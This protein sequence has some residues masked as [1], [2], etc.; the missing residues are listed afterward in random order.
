MLNNMDKIVAAGRL[1]DVVKIFGD[2][3]DSLALDLNA[4]V[5]ADETEV[6]D[7]KNELK[8]PNWCKKVSARLIA[9]YSKDV[10]RKKTAPI[11]AL[12]S[13]LSSIT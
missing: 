8:S 3:A 10:K 12:C 4:E 2:L 11:G 1:A 7:Y 9:Q 6:F 13:E 5:V